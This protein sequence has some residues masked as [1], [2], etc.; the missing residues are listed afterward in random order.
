MSRPRSMSRYTLRI[1]TTAS[2]L[3][4]EQRAD[5]KPGHGYKPDPPSRTRQ[6]RD[7]VWNNTWKKR[8]EWKYARRN[9]R[10]QWI[11][12]KLSKLTKLIVS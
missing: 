1:T 11:W 10:A 4:A 5:Y 8:E 12:L 7:R 6:I 2:A 3:T 9:K